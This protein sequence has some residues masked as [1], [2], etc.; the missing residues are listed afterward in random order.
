MKYFILIYYVLTLHI[1]KSITRKEKWTSLKTLKINYE[2]NL[3]TKNL[4]LNLFFSFPKHFL[5]RSNQITQIS[6]STLK[7][8]LPAINLSFHRLKY[9]FLLHHQPLCQH[10]CQVQEYENTFFFQGKQCY[11]YPCFKKILLNKLV[12]YSF[13]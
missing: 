3:N 6:K 2:V 11:V 5:P 4:N 1:I 7:H 13:L 9:L 12:R 10:R 8:T